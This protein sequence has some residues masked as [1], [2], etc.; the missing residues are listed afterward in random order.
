MI[1]GLSTLFKRSPRAGDGKELPMADRPPAS[2]A[3]APP[4]VDDVPRLLGAL[5]EAMAGLARSQKALLEAVQPPPR[6]K[7]PAPQPA[8]PPAQPAGAPDETFDLGGDPA[9]GAPPSGLPVDYSKL[10]PVQ[11]IAL[12]LRDAR[13]QGPHAARARAALARNSAPAAPE[14]ATGPAGAD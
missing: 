3:P 9:G 5:A 6:P 12:G 14:E 11:Q 1:P 4:A 13:P 10:S 8:A 2:P 7:D